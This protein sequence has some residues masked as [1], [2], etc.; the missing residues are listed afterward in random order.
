MIDRKMYRPLML[1][2]VLSACAALAEA[3]YSSIY[4][5]NS[6]YDGCCAY[7][8]DLMAQGPD[9]NL[10]GTMPTGQGSQYQ[11]GSWFEYSIGGGV[12][13]KGLGK[14]GIVPAQPNTGF[15]LGIDG[16]LYGGVVFG[17]LNGG[18]NG[19]LVKWSSSG[20]TPVYPFPGGAGG[21]APLAPPV[22]G[23][24]GNLYGVTYDGVYTGYVYQV[25]TATGTIGWV[26]PLPSGSR[27]PLI[28]ASDGNF[29]G[30]YPYGGMTINGVAP[31]NNNGGGVFR[32]TT[33]GVI[34]G[35][36]NLYPGS[37][38]N[39][40]MG[41]GEQP[42]GP[43]MQASDGNLYGTASGA[44]AYG[45]GVV[46]K[47][48]LNGTGF[49]VIHN[50][51]YADGTAPEGGLVQGSDGFLYGLASKDGAIKQ[52]YLPGGGPLFTVWGTLFKLD[53]TG[54]NFVRLFTFDK[55]VLNGQGPGTQ[56][57]ATPTL[58]TNGLFYGLTYAGGTGVV[59]P[60]GPGT[61]ND[62]GELFSYNLGLAPFISVV[63]QR[64]ARG[65]DRISIIGQGFYNATGVTFGGVPG[66]WGKFTVSIY[67]DNFMTVT[68]PQGAKTGPVIVQELG[69]KDLSTLYNF[70][71]NCT[72]PLC[73]RL[74]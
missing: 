27:A 64:A 16:N 38:N 70:T 34:S 49:S 53:T 66:T 2:L 32:V 14:G 68:V 33:A 35:V 18:N 26:H 13:T 19:M 5:F 62:G 50:F 55:S 69:G 3:Q 58:H 44:G 24:D 45:G 12:T 4:T 31:S 36:W 10:Y 73:L 39:N 43:V 41:D 40:G 54:A 9:G 56:P 17:G 8:A 7:Y 47:V 74:P 11:N 48:A 59:S 30:T 20:L 1:A 57:F 71:I 25:L 21:T 46:Y 37:S 65:G 52:V 61:F 22:Q 60:S 28:L 29:Y 67:S 42:W 72:G 6:S 63:G 23:P 15:T 51:Q